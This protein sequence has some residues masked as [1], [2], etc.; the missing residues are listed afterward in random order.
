M[1]NLVIFQLAPQCGLRNQNVLEAAA[2]V[3]GAVGLINLDIPS[4]VQSW[5]VNKVGAVGAKIGRCLALPFITAVL[6]AKRIGFFLGD[7][8]LHFQRF[9]AIGAITRHNFSFVWKTCL[10]FY[11]LIRNR[12]PANFA[13][14]PLAVLVFPIIALWANS[15]E[16][17]IRFIDAANFASLHR[18][19]LKVQAPTQSASVEVARQGQGLHVGGTKNAPYRVATSTRK[20]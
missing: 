12:L 17:W 18:H 19:T 13:A 2:V 11:S 15:A 4:M 7:V 1:N 8:G 16:I 14:L 3:L 5:A 9:A 20:V 10:A 6:V